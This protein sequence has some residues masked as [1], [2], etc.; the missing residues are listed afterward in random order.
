[1]T[2]EELFISFLTKVYNKTEDEVKPLIFDDKGEI[3]A[4]AFETLTGMDTARVTRLKGDSNGKFDDGYSKGKKE[5]AEKIEKHFKES[6][7]LDIEG[8][9]EAI[10]EATK[11]LMATSKAKGKDITED[12][13]K[14]HPAYLK[15]EKEYVPKT[16]HE[17]LLQDYDNYK[18]NIDRKIKFDKAKKI[19]MNE[20]ETFR[21]DFTPYND[22]PQIK[23]NLIQSYVSG[24]DSLDDIEFDD[25]DNIIA[26]VKGGKRVE[27][28][29]GNPMTFTK[30]NQERAGN[31]FKFLKQS[32]KGSAGNS[33][34]GNTTKAQ[35]FASKDEYTEA[36]SKLNTPEEKQQ[37]LKDNPMDKMKW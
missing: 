3:N 11:E 6:L 15:I 36:Y 34:D 10:S 20:L 9:Y 1:M 13:I 7:G 29:H 33:N 14:K 21:P 28:A 18:K 24:I 5:T 25:S 19:A 31:Y 16:E 2:A 32:E 23:Q 30:Y 4:D 8:N 12:D 37:F 17:K 27:D 22:A 26:I 35:T